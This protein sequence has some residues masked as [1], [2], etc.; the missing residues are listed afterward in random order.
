MLLKT[1]NVFVSDCDANLRFH[2]DV[3]V[4]FNFF[5][6]FLLNT[7][8]SVICKIARLCLLGNMTNGTNR[9]A[10]KMSTSQ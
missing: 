6:Q 4:Y 5:S 10:V 7:A 2:L 1:K 3:K 8:R 9:C